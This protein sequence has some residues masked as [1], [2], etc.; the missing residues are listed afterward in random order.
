VSVVRFS[1]AALRRLLSRPS[2]AVVC[3][4]TSFAASIGAAAPAQAALFGPTC[5]PGNLS[6]PF[7][8]W[9]DSSYYSLIPG[10]DFEGSLSAWTLSGG[11][12][13]VAGSEPYKATG[14]VG[15]YSL[16]LPAGASAQTPFVCVNAA[17]PAF[18][19]F[20]RNE[21]L[22]STLVV[23]VV[24]KTSLGPVTASLGTVL[25]STTWQPTLRMLTDSIVGGVLSGGTGQV[26]FRVSAL[27]GSSRI[28]D[29]FLDPR[30]H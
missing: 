26:A 28:D 3:I 8:P 17:Y 21:G 20:A 10:A 9:G 12:H 1:Q 19:F 6:Q 24:Y 2:V 11:A 22:I 27:T 13:T 15:R 30:M 7:L 5:S 4:A 16:Y 23:Q 14:S 29:L 18:R 25:A